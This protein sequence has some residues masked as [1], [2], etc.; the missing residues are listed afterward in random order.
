MNR[1]IS[2]I[3]ILMLLGIIPLFAQSLYIGGSVG[4]SFQKTKPQDVGGEELKFNKNGFAYKAYAGYRLAQFLGIEGGYRNLG[5]VKDTILDTEFESNTKGFDVFA[6]G[7]L[8]LATVDVFAKAGYFFW[9]T[10]VSASA[11]E[12]SIEDDDKDFAWGV[13]AAL[14]LGNFKVRAEWEQFNTGDMENLSMLTA[15]VV[16]SLF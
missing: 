2:F 16:I 6:T 11:G 3:V 1:F 12:I 5:K 13:G 4:S 14:S 9:N 10:E 8:N 7:T 15:G